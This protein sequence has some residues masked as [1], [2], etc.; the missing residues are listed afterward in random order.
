MVTHTHVEGKWLK[1]IQQNWKVWS[2]GSGMIEED[3]FTL[4]SLRWMHSRRRLGIHPD[5]VGSTGR[6]WKPSEK[7][8]AVDKQANPQV[9]V[10][11]N[12]TT[13]KRSSHSLNIIRFSRAPKTAAVVR[14]S[15][16][17]N[18]RAKT[19]WVS[20]GSLLLLVDDWGA[21]LRPTD[22]GKW[23]LWTARR[24]ENKE[25][26]GSIYTPPFSCCGEEI[27]ISF[28]FLFLQ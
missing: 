3:P 7:W 22:R 21:L 6:K 19:G 9:T 15:T 27:C 20:A 24:G 11:N 18:R 2:G 26:S 14:T 12:N 16:F 28:F 1:T 13:T 25:Y 10:S 5:F 4:S 17:H 23:G 8:D